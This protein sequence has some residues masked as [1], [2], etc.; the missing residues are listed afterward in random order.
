MGGHEFRRVVTESV[1][2]TQVFL[3]LGICGDAHSQVLAAFHRLVFDRYGSTWLHL[4]VHLG[5][6]LRSP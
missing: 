2:E 4:P 5:I 6:P 1:I 3:A